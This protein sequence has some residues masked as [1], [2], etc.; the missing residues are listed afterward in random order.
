MNRTRHMTNTNTPMPQDYEEMMRHY[1]P[2][3]PKALIVEAW[4]HNATPLEV[5]RHFDRI[6]TKEK[7]T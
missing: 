3:A 7:S 4:K 6:E 2:D 1:L 5:L